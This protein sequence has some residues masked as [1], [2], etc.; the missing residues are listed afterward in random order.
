[1]PWTYA[2]STG[3]LFLDEV[4]VGQGYAGKGPYKNRPESQFI[5]DLGPLP[6]GSYTIGP[7]QADGR[8]MGRN[9]LPL[10]PDPANDMGGRFAFFMH[11]DNADHTAS[12]GCIIMGPT[13]RAKVQQSEDRHLIVV[14]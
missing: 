10:T 13:I 6:Q 7:M 2:Q 14:A 9:V 8:H 5:S 4:R 12:N 1:M 11:G 3:E